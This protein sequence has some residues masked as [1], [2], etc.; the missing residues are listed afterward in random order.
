MAG[1]LGGNLEPPSEGHHSG[2]E[3]RCSC[4][5]DNCC[6]FIFIPSPLV[7]HIHLVV[8]RDGLGRRD[9]NTKLGAQRS[10][11]KES[12]EGR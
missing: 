2:C 3:Q 7:H 9:Q 6:Y 10:E 12:P 8:T 4:H 11:W 1:L 5:C